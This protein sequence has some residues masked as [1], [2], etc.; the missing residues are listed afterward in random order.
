[1]DD[2]I[3][4][5]W[6]IRYV[7]GLPTRCRCQKALRE[8]ILML[9][10]RDGGLT[11]RQLADAVGTHQA[12]IEELLAALYAD[13]EVQRYNA[14]SPKQRRMTEYWCIAGRS[15]VGTENRY[16]GAETLAAFQ[17]AALERLREVR[18]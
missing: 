10:N 5:V 3:T 2:A 8:G 16:R 14:I 17:I 13:G 1:M 12:V 18:A 11:K 6:T 15:P 7:N 4:K 9:L